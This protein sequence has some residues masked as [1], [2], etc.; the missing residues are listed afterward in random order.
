MTISFC[1]WFRGPTIGIHYTHCQPEKNHEQGQINFPYLS[2]ED[3]PDHRPTFDTIAAHWFQLC[4]PWDHNYMETSE[5]PFVL[6]CFLLLHGGKDH[7]HLRLGYT[8]SSCNMY[9]VGT[10][11]NSFMSTLGWFLESPHTDCQASVDRGSIVF[12]YAP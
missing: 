8:R 11:L 1:I 12:S 6:F 5:Q 4:W 3:F 10:W 9:I 7:P 2:R